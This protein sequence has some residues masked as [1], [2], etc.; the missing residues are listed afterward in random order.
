MRAMLPVGSLFADY[1]P[2]LSLCF[3]GLAA[4]AA[5]A[6]CSCA[7]QTSPNVHTLRT[8]YCEQLS[9]CFLENTLCNF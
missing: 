1:A 2:A 4:G 9:I 3:L 8:L 5:T 7:A 6:N